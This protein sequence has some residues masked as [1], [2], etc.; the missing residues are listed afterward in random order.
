MVKLTLLEV[1]LDDASFSADHPF[2][3]VTASESADSDSDEDDAEAAPEQSD[4]DDEQGDAD[5]VPE[6]PTKALATVGVLLALVGLAAAVKRLAGGED[7]DVEIE[8]SEDDEN[9]PVG[10]T[11]DE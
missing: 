8:T 2:S 11:V 1:H 6:L 9:R 4:G 10:V 7:P 3:N 5:A